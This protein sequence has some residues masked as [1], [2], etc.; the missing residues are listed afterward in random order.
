MKRSDPYI[1]GLTGGIACGKSHV[2]RYMREAGIPV[3]DADAVSRSV[4]AGGGEALPAIRALFGDAVFDGEELDRRALGKIV[5][6]DS[7][8]RRQLE[9]IIHPLVI[10]RMRRETEEAASPIVGWDVP[11]LYETGLD[12]H[13]G[14]VWCVYADREEQIRRIMKRDGLTAEEAEARI[15]SQMPVRD[16]MARAARCIGTMGEREETRQLVLGLVEEL[17]RRLCLE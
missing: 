5:F 8:K 15:D 7:E 10:S 12:R 11:L 3:L 17:K 9:N 14:E 16:K 4:T 13:C 1:I 6:A 2:A